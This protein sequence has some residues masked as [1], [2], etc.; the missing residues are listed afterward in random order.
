MKVC[1][2]A[3]RM[4]DEQADVDRLEGRTLAAFFAYL[5]GKRDEKLSKEREEAMEAAVRY[6]SAD[7]E[8]AAVREDIASLSAERKTLAGCDIRYK[9][10]L[11]ERAKLLRDEGNPEL[12]ACEERIAAIDAQLDELHEALQAG[13]VALSTANKVLNHLNSAG[14][15]ATYDALGGGLLSD[16][17]K[18]GELDSAEEQIR[19][20]QIEIGRFRTELADV[21]IDTDISVGV[22]ES[23]RFADYF[24]DNIFTDW[25]VRDRIE[26]S[27]SQVRRTAGQIERVIGRLEGIVDENERKRATELTLKAE[28]LAK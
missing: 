3:Y 19:T 8:L 13:S 9:A 28:L 11:E 16:L 2:L 4:K 18:Y 6:H 1:E 21:R 27:L 10:A 24:F 26:S 5:T 23:L 12:L 20:L 17:A 22:D 15:W 7:A 14:G 25:A